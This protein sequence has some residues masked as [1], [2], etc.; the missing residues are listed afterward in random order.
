MWPLPEIG[1]VTD[2]LPALEGSSQLFTDVDLGLLGL[3]HGGGQVGDL[4]AADGIGVA[5]KVCKD[6][7]IAALT[8]EPENVYT[9]VHV[10]DGMQ[11]VGVANTGIGTDLTGLHTEAADKS[12]VRCIANTPTHLGGL[13]VCQCKLSTSH[14]PLS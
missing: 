8:V 12:N 14:D 6:D 11:D 3:Q 1:L 4:G 5:A 7:G 10:T 9:L 2:L 13:Q